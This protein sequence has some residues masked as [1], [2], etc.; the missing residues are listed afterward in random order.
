MNT[1]RG[2]KFYEDSEEPEDEVRFELHESTVQ[3][4]LQPPTNH[5]ISSSSSSAVPSVNRS[6]FQSRRVTR[7]SVQ[8]H[9]LT[10]GASAISSA[11][12]DAFAAPTQERLR[13]GV[14]SL[15]FLAQHSAPSQVLS[16]ASEVPPAP[17]PPTSSSSSSS[18]SSSPP[19]DE[20]AAAGARANDPIVADAHAPP[21]LA[22]N[23]IVPDRRPYANYV[24]SQID[25]NDDDDQQF[26]HS[27]D[28]DND[29]GGGHV[30]KQNDSSTLKSFLAD[31]PSHW[32]GGQ[33]KS[34]PLAPGN[35]AKK[36]V[37]SAKRRS[38]APGG[39]GAEKKACLETHHPP[40]KLP[41]G[42]K[43]LDAISFRPS[44]MAAPS[45]TNPYYTHTLQYLL[46]L[47]ICIS[48]ICRSSLSR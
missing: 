46:L 10:E 18:S 39:A 20:T 1:R 7:A 29:N 47:L 11:Q 33:R 17:R 25:D 6:R 31:R 12:I 41:Q 24:P 37:A 8:P 5:Q 14:A 15:L 36:G 23:R 32:G 27:Y 40:M 2:L 19:V 30:Y 28:D 38:S 45:G 13:S 9:G 21:I 48:S 4:V 43:K 3:F 35:A 16:A 26:G 22:D 34:L 44:W 42:T